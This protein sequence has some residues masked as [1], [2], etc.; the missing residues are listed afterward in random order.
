[1]SINKKR[2]IFSSANII[3][4]DIKIAVYS[5]DL[6]VCLHMLNFL[7]NRK[8]SVTTYHPGTKERNKVNPNTVLECSMHD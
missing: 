7:V 1:M 3:F 2:H 5:I 8:L 6:G 4:T